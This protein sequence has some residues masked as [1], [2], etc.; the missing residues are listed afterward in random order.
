MAHIGTPIVGD[1]VYG[2][3]F[4]TKASALPEEQAQMFMSM[5]RQALH[6]FSLRLKHPI[7]GKVETFQS[8]LPDD[9]AKLCRG[10]ESL[11]AKLS[12]N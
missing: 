3:G 2:A 4:R 7:T 11:E 12:K 6:A 9:I 10:L 5:E 1:A 8:A